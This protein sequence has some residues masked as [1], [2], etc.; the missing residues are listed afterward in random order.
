MS[1]VKGL[2]DWL[3]YHSTLTQIS[4]NLT[5]TFAPSNGLR[6]LPQALVDTIE[7]QIDRYPTVEDETSETFHEK[8]KQ[9]YVKHISDD[10]T[11]LP[12]FLQALQ[13]LRPWMNGAERKLH[14][15]NVVVKPILDNVGRLRV[16]I[17]R[18][19]AFMIAILLYDVNDDPDGIKAKESSFFA[20]VVLEGYLN[21]T[22]WSSA[23]GGDYT[24]ENEHCAGQ[25]E[26]VLLTFGK[27]KPKDIMLALDPLIVQP[28]HRAQAL[29]LLALVVQNQ[30]AFL[31]LVSET[32]LIEHLIQC[33]MIDSSTTVV[34]T[35]MTALIMFLPHI[36]TAVRVHLP[37]L[38]LIYSRLICWDQVTKLQPTEKTALDA[39]IE[40]APSVQDEKSSAPVDAADIDWQKVYCSAEGEET[41]P[42]DI[43]N[44][45]T[46]LYGLYPLNFLGFVRKPRRYLKDIDFP[47]AE[48]LDLNPDTIKERTAPLRELHRLHPNFYEF[49]IDDELQSNRWLSS[50]SSE[51]VAECIALRAYLPKS[52]DDP[53]PPPTS[54][55]PPIP[56]PNRDR[57]NDIPGEGI[58]QAE[59][60]ESNI[61]T[62]DSANANSNGRRQSG[63]LASH[64][65]HSPAP[66][67]RSERIIQTGSPRRSP[68]TP[69]KGF[70]DDSGDRPILPSS[71]PEK[72][73]VADTPRMHSL[74]KL[75]LLK[76]RND[77]IFE[78][79]LR[80][81]QSAHVGHLQRRH[82]SDATMTANYENIMNLNKTLTSR[83]TKTNDA[84]AALKKDVSTKR[85]QSKAFELEL[86]NKV[87]TLRSSE[88]DWLRE[89]EELRADR[90]RQARDAEALKKI[91]VTAE[92]RELQSSQQVDAMRFDLGRAK[93]AH[94][95]AS[96]LDEK[97]KDLK[98]ENW[99]HEKAAAISGTRRTEVHA[100]QM[101]LEATRGDS[102]RMEEGYIKQVTELASRVRELEMW[103][104]QPKVKAL[105]ERHNNQSNTLAQLRT[106][107]K[108]L[109]HENIELDIRLKDL[110][111]DMVGPSQGLL[112][113]KSRPSEASPSPHRSD[114]GEDV[115]PSSSHPPS[116]Y[117]GGVASHSFRGSSQTSR[118]M[119]GADN[120]GHGFGGASSAP[121]KHAPPFPSGSRSL[122]P[123]RSSGNMLSETGSAS[124]FDSDASGST[125]FYKNKK[126]AFSA[127]SFDS[128]RT[129][130]S[131]KTKVSTKSEKRVFGRGGSQNIGKEDGEEVEEKTKVKKKAPPKTGGL[132]G[133]RGLM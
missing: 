41:L 69:F 55:L 115:F 128:T 56:V 101:Q 72:A 54:K 130:G 91:V 78:R 124:G 110:E 116:S 60:A 89:R 29:H 35:A 12:A 125:P 10:Q 36:P 104:D 25:F 114:G 63:S 49:T 74:Q 3:S 11:R 121:T 7:Q 86:S 132:R 93:Q 87:R 40:Q 94:E 48:Q 111:S 85:Q 59:D 70:E 79:Y 58:L 122:N 103:E 98:H 43:T 123:N 65:E 34:Q 62:N 61:S 26:H 66:R 13:L 107:Y 37:R 57:T 27:K 42:L 102:E 88:R 46:F 23:E 112:R 16:E 51:I 106:D 131:G 120:E 53:G 28:R 47:R 30:L 24:W 77:I 99:E 6:D 118:T 9:I 15:W 113:K 82:V 119:G 18:A 76:A 8:L 67:S 96:E 81:Q 109:R 22:M 31:H 127:D 105:V 80:Q 20:K 126:S 52:Y 133:I 129:G 73:V 108:A 83:L 14:W 32:P 2:A 17:E 97:V 19:S 33:L 68:R 92:S 4:R 84:Y 90:D 64:N 21:R 45:F 75:D 38:F 44:F 1:F 100:L 39:D 71:E 50:D 5:E 117:R 95:R